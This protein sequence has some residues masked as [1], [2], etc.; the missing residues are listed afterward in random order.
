V[1]IPKNINGQ[2]KIKTFIGEYDALSIQSKAIEAV[3]KYV[4]F[5]KNLI[6]IY[7]V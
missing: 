7:K 5:K 1:S 3:G 2:A 6:V 4:Y